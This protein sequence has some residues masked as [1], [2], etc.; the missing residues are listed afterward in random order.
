[1]GDRI[2]RVTDDPRETLFLFHRRP[3]TVAIQ[4]FNA[5]ILQILYATRL[6]APQAFRSTTKELNFV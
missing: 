1:M 3:I 6:A 4:D 2:S 5:V